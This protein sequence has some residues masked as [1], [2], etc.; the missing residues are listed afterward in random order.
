MSQEN[1]KT[2]SDNEAFLNEA[3]EDIN[4]QDSDKLLDNNNQF[5]DTQEKKSGWKVKIKDLWQNPKKRKIVI[6]STVAVIF[7][8]A[9]IPSSRYFVLNTVGVRSSA[10]VRVL[11]QSTGQPLKNV[12]VQ[13]AGSEKYKSTLS[14][15][16][17]LA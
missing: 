12:T 9:I 14:G 1:Q 5:S 2:E 16:M 6:G 15:C 8:I 11:D 17:H 13:I 10:S 7:F 4:K 3:I